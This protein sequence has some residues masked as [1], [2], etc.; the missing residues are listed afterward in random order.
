MEHGVNIVDST[1]HSRTY[2]HR[3]EKYARRGFAVALPGFNVGLVSLAL[4]T[5]TFVLMKKHDLLLRIA[6][7]ADPGVSTLDVPAGGR[8]MTVRCKKQLATRVTGIKRLVVLSY[9][10]HAREVEP[11][12][13]ARSAPRLVSAQN[14]GERG[15][16]CEGGC[17]G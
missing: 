11:P 7:S 14:L 6:H 10:R 15:A 9:S 12:Y 4:T 5:G 17:S 3:L 16:P 2:F 8:T 13:L 1:R